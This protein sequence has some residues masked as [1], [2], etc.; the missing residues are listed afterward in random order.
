MTAH[1]L[2][3]VGLFGWMRRGAC[4][5]APGTGRWNKRKG[6]EI[7]EGAWR[8]LAIGSPVTIPLLPEKY[9]DYQTKLHEAKGTH[10]GYHRHREGSPRRGTSDLEAEKITE[11]ATLESLGIDSLD[12]VELICDPRGRS[13]SVGSS[14]EPEGIE[15][16]GQLVAHRFAVTR[17]LIRTGPA[18][19]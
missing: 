9:F 12:M 6:A 8:L 10:H 17:Q 15:T 13:A 4:L 19:G 14:G 1:A 5:G 7:V 16:V 18:T 2:F 3:A 11:E